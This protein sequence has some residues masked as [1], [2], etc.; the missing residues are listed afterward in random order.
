MTTDVWFTWPSRE[1]LSHEGL[2]RARL[3]IMWS[4]R[5]LLLGGM[6]WTAISE[7]GPHGWSWAV[8]VAMVLVMVVLARAFWRQT[9]AH[10]MWP[11][12]GLLALLMT[13]AI[14]AQQTDW[15]IFATIA[16]CGCAVSALER[17]P[18][19]A[20]VPTTLVA[21]GAYAALNTDDWLTTALT[22]AGLGLAGY[23]LR[24]DAEARGTAQRLLAQERA[25]R[26]AEAESAALAERARIAREIHDVLA[27]SLSAQLVHLEAARLMI[28]RE[29]A[30][31][32]RDR[33]LERVVAARSMAR[34]GLAET[35]QA[36]SALRGEITP[37][38]GFLRTLVDG[39]G[40]GGLSGPAGVEVAGERRPLTAEASQ[41]VRRVA[42]EALTNVR[43]HAPGAAV[44]VRLEY[45]PDEVALE[46]RDSGG[47]RGTEEWEASG[48]GYGLLG[49]RE[50]AELL[51][52]TLEAG[53]EEEGFV[54]RLRV[55]A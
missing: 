3:G 10:R 33:I 32:F 8:G 15:R 26:A 52:G 25:A 38:E 42:Q 51:G 44:A 20:A 30:G 31:E 29:P 54:V 35:R 19:G 41:A 4:V 46:V 45:R 9:L 1:A 53:P 7:K 22:T 43:K 27:H 39:G 13:T 28:E 24:L 16:W 50:R 12:L 47:G 17:L 18:L 34:D 48:S 6:L 23:V 36:L 11:S 37:V 40:L 5:G 14:A 49:M 2:S 21:L 55:P